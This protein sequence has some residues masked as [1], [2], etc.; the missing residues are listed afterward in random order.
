MTL[1]VLCFSF[2]RGIQ[3]SF[4]VIPCKCSVF[5]TCGQLTTIHPRMF[6]AKVRSSQIKIRA[7]EFPSFL[8]AD[9]S[10][11]DP[12]KPHRGLL[13]G[14]LLVRVC[15][16]PHSFA[17]S[18]NKLWCVDFSMY[19]YRPKHGNAKGCKESFQVAGGDS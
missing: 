11:Y 6:M 16:L 7:S 1:S 10:K 17:F 5:V 9:A 15:D 8:Y 13:K 19:L 3:M 12:N 18:S 14:P 2:H 4:S